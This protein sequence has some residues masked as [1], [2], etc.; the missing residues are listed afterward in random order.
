MRPRLAQTS[1]LK[2]VI[3][4]YLLAAMRCCSV[5]EQLRQIMFQLGQHVKNVEKLLADAA[6]EN[7][8]IFGDRCHGQ[9]LVLGEYQD[10]PA[11]PQV[12]KWP[13]S[14]P[15]YP[16]GPAFQMTTESRSPSERLLPR[17]L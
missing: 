14:D 11:Q 8:N 15:A 2:D 7:T 12:Q 3:G 5:N 10:Q 4:C 13:S 16:R 6:A 1:T 17:S 9:M